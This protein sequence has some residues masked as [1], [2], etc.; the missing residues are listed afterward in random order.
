MAKGRL[1][2][3]VGHKHWGKSET[4]KALSGGRRLRWLDIN[5][6]L[7]FVRRMSNDDIPK[8]YVN[9]LK[10]LDPKKKPNVILALCPTF[11]R[12]DLCTELV[13][14]LNGLKSK[15]EIFFF[16]LRHS[17][18]GDR[19]ISDHETTSLETFG[20]VKVCRDSRAAAK[21]RAEELRGFIARNV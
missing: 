20:T 6:R 7:F 9:L 10:E 19:T 1:F 11:E 17:Y 13:N 3:V 16:V 5:A 8:D 12:E 14:A 21:Q 18:R 2:A 15:Y 4:L